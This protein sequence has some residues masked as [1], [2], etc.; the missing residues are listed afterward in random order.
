MNYGELKEAVQG[1]LYDRSDLAAV[2][3]T[4]IDMA[5]RKI[6]RMLRVPANERIAHFPD[7][8]SGSI[9]LPVDFLEAKILSV[10]GVPMTRISDL[11]HMHEQ[12]RRGAS[13]PPEQFSRIG[14]QLHLYPTPDDTVNVSLVY[15]ADLSGTLKMDTDTNE[16]LRIAADA[17]L[18]GAL[19]EASAYLGQ[20]SRIPVW[21]S[22]YAEA[23]SAIQQQA[24]EAEYAG[25]VTSVRNAYP[26]RRGY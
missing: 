4:F 22:K 23:V 12:D 6:Y 8:D 20:D 26:E 24:A 2:I 9:D 18:H 17:Y 19:V 16:M 21:Q 15:W 10:D 14:A 3:P 25:S 1:Y 11:A 5:E 13:G 7:H